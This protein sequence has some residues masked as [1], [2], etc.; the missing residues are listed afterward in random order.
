M[1][2]LEIEPLPY[3]PDALEPYIGAETV[4][5]H[6]R[7]HHASHFEKLCTAIRTQPLAQLTLDEIVTRAPAGGAVLRN[8]AEVWNH[9]FYWSSLTPHG[10]GKPDRET[11][12]VIKQHFG[13]VGE[14]KRQF[15]EAAMDEF[16]CGW[17]WLVVDGAGRLSVVTT[18]AADNPMRDGK[19][20]I[21]ALDLWEH[22][23]YLNYRHERARYVEACIDHLLNWRFAAANIELALHP[24]SAQRK[25]FVGTNVAVPMTWQEQSFS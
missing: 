16:G 3:A 22:A 1:V 15:A 21:I 14:F 7:K 19:W 25:G 4:D 23:Y 12:N 11:A 17:A 2:L 24:R 13:S 8:A 18:T 20:P 9:T 5:I 10:G 6:Y